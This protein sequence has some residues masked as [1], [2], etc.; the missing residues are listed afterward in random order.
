[1]RITITIDTDTNDIKVVNDTPKVTPVKPEPELP[2]YHSL[3]DGYYTQNSKLFAY[4]R[5]YKNDS[6]SDS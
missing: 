2:D 5:L 3:P 1:M 6:D 4:P